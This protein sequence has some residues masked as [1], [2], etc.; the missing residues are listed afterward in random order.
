[1]CLVELTATAAAI[2]AYTPYNV[3]IRKTDPFG[4]SGI[5]HQFF[6]SGL[7]FCIYL[8]FIYFF[9]LPSRDPASITYANKFC[10]SVRTLDAV[11]T[12]PLVCFSETYGR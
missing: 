8:F 1:M 4:T 2:C 6:D 5:F 3:H 11:R 12:V 7:F 9:L 10:N